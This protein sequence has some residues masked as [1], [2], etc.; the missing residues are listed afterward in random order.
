MLLILIDIIEKYRHL[1]V[2]MVFS[3]VLTDEILFIADNGKVM[4]L[5]LQ[6]YCVQRRNW[7]CLK[8]P[9]KEVFYSS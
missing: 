8:K 2:T 6:V 7:K 9:Q 1:Q 3:M 4:I 5:H